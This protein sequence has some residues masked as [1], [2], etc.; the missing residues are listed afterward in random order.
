MGDKHRITK[1]LVVKELSSLGLYLRSPPSKLH[2]PFFALH[3]STLT[4]E[5]E[6][7]T[8][9]KNIIMPY[10][11]MMMENFRSPSFT[12]SLPVGA[13]FPSWNFWDMNAS[14]ELLSCLQFK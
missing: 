6:H 5:N 2:K 3:L 1:S 13:R 10:I 11:F 12:V 4:P 14:D 7:G 9:V 8:L